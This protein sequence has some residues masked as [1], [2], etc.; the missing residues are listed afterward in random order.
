MLVTALLEQAAGAR[1]ASAG[2]RHRKISDSV[3]T[4]PTIMD[5]S[6]VKV[7]GSSQYINYGYVSTKLNSNNIFNAREN[8]SLQKVL[9]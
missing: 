9:I 3:H 7:Q 8:Q 1:K 5:E 2:P 6:P 4:L